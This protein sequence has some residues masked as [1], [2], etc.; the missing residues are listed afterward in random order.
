MK[1]KYLAYCSASHATS[2][3]ET[4]KRSIKLIYTERKGQRQREY[5][6]LWSLI[7]HLSLPERLRLRIYIWKYQK[8]L[9]H[10]SGEK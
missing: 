4:I 6:M 10:L 5:V 8:D 1:W 2:I 3:V 7:S 9:T